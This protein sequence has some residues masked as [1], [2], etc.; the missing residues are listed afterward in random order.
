MD[1]LDDF[2]RVRQTF[3]E[4][5]DV[6]KRLDSTLAEETPA[7]QPAAAAYDLPSLSVE[8]TVK[9]AARWVPGM[10]MEAN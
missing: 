1:L 6:G 2:D 5:S 9:Q 4:L 10:L 3:A 8:V 7:I